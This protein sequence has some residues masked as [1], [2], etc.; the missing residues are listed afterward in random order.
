VQHFLLDN[1]DGE[2]RGEM[3]NP[4]SRPTLGWIV[5]FLL[6]PAGRAFPQTC[7]NPPVG[8]IGWWPGDGSGTNISVAADPALAING[9][10]Y[11]AGM[12]NQAFNLNGLNQFFQVGNPSD[13][14]LGNTDFTVDAW[15]RFNMIPKPGRRTPDGIPAGDM[16]IVDKML[17][18]SI[19]ND[20]GWRLIKQDDNHFWFC[21]GR[22]GSSNGCVAGGPT[23]VQSNTTVV[24]ARWYHVAGVRFGKTISIY[25]NGLLEAQKP[26]A[27]TPI[28]NDLVD[29]VFG[30]HILYQAGG[31]GK[32]SSFL[33]GMIDEVEIFNRA[34]AAS[35][36]AAIYSAG[37]KGKC[38]TRNEPVFEYA[39]KFVCGR[40]L[41]E[42]A[43]PGRY[44]TVINVHNPSLA[45]V[46]FRKKF[47][48]VGREAERGGRKTEFFPAHL[49]PDA[50]F[51][52][53]CKDI[54]AHAGIG[55]AFAD[56][57]AVLESPIEL[58][59]EG[60]YTAAG[61]G[62]VEAMELERVPGRRMPSPSP[63]LLADLIPTP[64]D[65]RYCVIDST[66]HL[67]VTVTNQ[68][69]GP[70]GTSR[71]RVVFSGGATD[72]RMIGTL[73]T[74]AFIV[75]KIPMNCSARDCGVTITVDSDG[76]VTESNETNNVV[77]EAC[78]PG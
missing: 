43:A 6:L 74:G 1:H 55:T 44:F 10:G 31:P 13:L 77:S 28:N 61:A 29:L 45:P 18:K 35:E 52:I 19:Y 65:G 68:G 21:F 17:T 22:A 40:S 49:E 54:G 26:F 11:A 72:S 16:A 20:D 39:A 7:I 75:V 12:V 53:D 70:A 33:D 27:D 47:A 24:A 63:Q 50:A 23:T 66:N 4:K 64:R 37:E 71:V 9:A 25:V 56:G 5:F 48:L 46:E 36:I 3:S 8:L 51:A 76:V 73:A 41:G 67:V 15:V 30:M 34:L 38:K 57:F 62:Q 32:N 60:V 59:V 14:K 42:R 78:F 2:V 58:D 69:A